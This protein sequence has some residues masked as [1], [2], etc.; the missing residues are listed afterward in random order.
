MPGF[1]VKLR[2]ASPWRIGP[3]N[4]E[5]DR[6]GRVF[7]SDAL[8]AAVTSAMARLDHLDDWLEA[9][10]YRGPST[11]VRFS[12]CFPLLGD[13]LFAPP[14]R[15]LWPPA[16]SLKVR[17]KGARFVPLSVIDGLLTGK[18]PDEDKWTVDGASEC[19][20]PV[21]APQPGVVAQPA[22]GPF[23]V[24]L[25]GSAAVDR[26]G[27]G[28]A[29]HAVACLE[30]SPGAGLWTY[31]E[32]SSEEAATRWTGAV[33]AAFRWL[34]DSGF[35][36]ERSRGWGRA[37]APEFVAGPLPLRVASS[38]APAATTG[39]WW[40][41]SLLQ[42]APDDAVDWERG[43]YALTLR[44]GRVESSRGWGA[45]KRATRMVAEGSVLR[46]HTRPRGTASDVAPENFAHPVY[47]AGFAVAVALPAVEAP[48]PKPAAAPVVVVA[49]PAGL[50][51]QP[52]AEPAAE[53]APP[54]EDAPSISLESIL[55]SMAFDA[56]LDQEQKDKEQNEAEGQP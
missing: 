54:A 27:A 47:R 44:G 45:E 36:G 21:P 7:H 17:W 34:A 39:N 2:A 8:Y 11:E 4:G 22:T 18:V 13:M 50:S 28:V 12:S 6:A 41:L 26:G 23:R 5:R 16:A 48:K 55:D 38:A 40:M 25:R 24:S 43:D 49:K 31:V 42:P 46:A 30:F 20:V 51:S 19:L 14:P 10:A 32:F 52:A 53:P 3:E 1:L 15:S 33:Q 56:V 35:G 9:T 37:Q 29:P